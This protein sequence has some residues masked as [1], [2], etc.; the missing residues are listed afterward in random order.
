MLIV[1]VVS[2]FVTALI[3]G[4]I[5]ANAAKERKT[6]AMRWIRAGV[7]VLGLDAFGDFTWL[8]VSG[9]RLPFAA[10]MIGA[11]LWSLLSTA[12]VVQI[13]RHRRRPS[14]AE[15]V[16]TTLAALS[17]SFG[18][19]W[20]IG[21]GTIVQSEDVG[22]LNRGLVT[23]ALLSVVVQITSIIVSVKR[24][25]QVALPGFSSFAAGSLTISFTYVMTAFDHLGITASVRIP[26]EL[27]GLVGVA[28]LGAS[29]WGINAK[30]P[31]RSQRYTMA[32]LFFLPAIITVALSIVKYAE[33][34]DE[35]VF[36][37]T[38]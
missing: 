15:R 10:S 3:C 14:L 25:E 36:G 21:L 13:L 5:V 9:S 35:Y 26:V 29:L 6:S 16:T 18:F 30:K 11:I 19:I 32:P 31:A 34:T 20:L 12:G 38:S 7:L 2:S 24:T 8:A 27:F 37:F 33:T 23:I 4:I 22:P 28:G 17:S 1:D